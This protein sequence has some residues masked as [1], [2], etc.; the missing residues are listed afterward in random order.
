MRSM[1]VNCLYFNADLSCFNTS[2]VTDMGGMFYTAV[3][4][5]NINSL[6]NW[7]VRNV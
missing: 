3:R 7:N 1:F 6:R 4:F 5:N 2:N